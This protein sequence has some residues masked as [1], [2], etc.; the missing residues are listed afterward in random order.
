MSKHYSLTIRIF[1]VR[2]S[3]YCLHL[4]QKGHCPYIIYQLDP[5]LWRFILKREGSLP[6]PML[7]GKERL[8]PDGHGWTLPNSWKDDSE[9]FPRFLHSSSFCRNRTHV[10]YPLEIPFRETFIL[11]KTVWINIYFLIWWKIRKITLYTYICLLECIT[12]TQQWEQK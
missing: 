10:L 5:S 12:L 4:W 6:S 1:S 9:K 11:L 7:W 8:V 2:E 3:V